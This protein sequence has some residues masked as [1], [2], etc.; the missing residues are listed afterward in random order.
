MLPIAAEV[1]E[2]VGS[3]GLSSASRRIDSASEITSSCIV[4]YLSQSIG[5]VNASA[6]FFRTSMDI[7]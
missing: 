5:F 1:D 6:P 4:K 2:V 3:V 7:V